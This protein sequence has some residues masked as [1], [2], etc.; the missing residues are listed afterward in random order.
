MS[1]I[2]PIGLNIEAW[3]EWCEF[4]RIE[5]KNPVGPLGAKKQHKMLV[6]YPY[7]VQQQIIDT[8][9][10]GGWT[11]LFAPKTPIKAANTM[12]L[13]LD[14]EWAKDLIATDESKLL[15]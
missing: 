4:R 12:D 5:K 9:I 2:I 13:L 15:N 11:G 14:R 6:K 3:N 10:T 1:Y 8:S 7:E